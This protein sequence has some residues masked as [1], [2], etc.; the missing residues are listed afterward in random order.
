MGVEVERK[1]LVRHLDWRDGIEGKRYLQGYVAEQAGVVVRARMAGEKGRLTIKGPSV[2]ASRAEFEY[3]IPPADVREMLAS[4]CPGGRVEKTRYKVPVGEHVWD[5]DVFHGDNDG[6]VMAEVELAHPD[7]A[8]VRPDW[9]GREVTED[10]R[11][12][13]AYLA[14]NP[15]NTWDERPDAG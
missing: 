6:L 9:A 3:A 15:W 10:A 1:F 2:G 5:V 4:L 12:F 7:E 8:F 13:N 14:K 11:F